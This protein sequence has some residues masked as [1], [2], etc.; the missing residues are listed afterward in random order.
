LYSPYDT[1][2]HLPPSGHLNAVFHGKFN[3]PLKRAIGIG[4]LRWNG[5]EHLSASMPG[6]YMTL[7]A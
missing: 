3:D 7:Y 1:Q 2:D 6:H 4:V 5:R